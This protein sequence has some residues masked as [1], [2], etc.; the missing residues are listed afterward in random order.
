MTEQQPYQ[1]VHDYGA[2]E[3]RRYPQHVVA[4]VTVDSSFESAG[5]RAFRHLFAYISGANSTSSKIAMTAPV[6]QRDAHPDGAASSHIEAA[7]PLTLSQ[8]E[9]YRVSFVLPASVTSSSA[10]APADRA[11]RLRTVSESIVAATRYSGRW[12]EARYRARLERLRADVRAAGLTPI[13]E[14][15]SARFDPPFT[16]PFL[17]RNEVLIDVEL[18]A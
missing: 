12:S 9:S 15:T 7:D 16:P 11:V 10:P 2:F 18:G 4:D 5:N 8:E 17:R 14:G 6:L 1:V 13:G 3:V